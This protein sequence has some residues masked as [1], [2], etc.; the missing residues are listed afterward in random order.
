MDW[1]RLIRWKNLLI[2]F[3]TQLLVWYCL[4]YDSSAFFYNNFFV[5]DELAQTGQQMPESPHLLLGLGNFMLISLST[6]LI[7]AAGYIIND[8][9]DIKIDIINRPEKVI[10]EKRIPLRVA[11]LAH[12][13]LNTLALVMT[14]VVA[15]QA[16]HIEWVFVQLACTMTLWFYSTHFKRQLVTGNVVVALLTAL[17]IVVLVL[18]EPVLHYYLFEP[19][20]LKFTKREFY[21]NPLWM[22]GTYCF[23]AFML[24]WMR[25]IVK[26]IE[27]FKGDSEQGC[28]TMPIKMGLQYSVRFTQVLGLITLVVLLL[29]VSYLV[30]SAY[31]MLSL[32]MVL[33]VIMPMLVWCVFVARKTT[34]EH[35]HVASRWL[36]MIMVAG[37]CSLIVYH[38]TILSFS[39]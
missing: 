36:K 28:M 7:T 19:V 27:D 32:Y 13:F 22:C 8:Y 20:V 1:L 35:Y 16:H 29:I 21:I 25:E 2:V 9:F 10:L 34:T 11:I 3:L 38:F 39:W 26:D 33:L 30:R 5:S 18:Y 4:I 24:T 6:V 15:L 23:F 31:N 14:G 37:I 17:T 12:I